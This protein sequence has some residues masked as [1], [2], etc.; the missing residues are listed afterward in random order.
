[1]SL[2]YM[3][4]DFL[5]FLVIAYFVLVQ[6]IS[7][8]LIAPWLSTTHKYDELFA[9]QSRLVNKSWFIAFQIMGSYTGGG[10]SLVDAG[11]VP[12]QQAYLMI[13]AMLFAILA[14]NHGLPIL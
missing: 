3:A 7:I 10:M 14:G 5:S 13:F 6:L 4:L 9:S 8:V 12:F 1:M 11:M 2:R